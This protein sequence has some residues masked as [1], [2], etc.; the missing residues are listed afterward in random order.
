MKILGLFL[1]P[2]IRTGGHRR[3]LELL[4]GLAEKGHQVYLIVNSEIDFNQSEPVLYI[5]DIPEWPE[6]RRSHCIY[7]AV[8]QVS[9][10]IPVQGF[11]SI[12]IFGETHFQ[13]ARYLKKKFKSP[14]IFGY[15]SD[16][17]AEAVTD[18]RLKKKSLKNSLKFLKTGIAILPLWFNNRLWSG[19]YCLSIRVRQTHL[20]PASSM[21]R[22]ENTC[23]WG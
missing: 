16:M 5:C 6:K 13:A 8:K 1:N 3:Y 19:P 22:T 17:I 15:R 7:K 20:V 9:E 10:K 2:E 23:Y 14:L 4:S 11:D 18:Y 21:G 12:I